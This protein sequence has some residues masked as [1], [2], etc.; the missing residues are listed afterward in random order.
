MRES[1]RSTC[2]RRAPRRAS[3]AFSLART[4]SADG[5]GTPEVTFPRKRP[6]G[7]PVFW[8]AHPG[9]DGRG[10]CA[11]WA[12]RWSPSSP[13]ACTRAKDAAELVAID[14]EDLPCV[15]DTASRDRR[16]AGLGRNARTTSRMLFEV[17]DA[18]ATDAAFARAARI[19]KGRYVIS[20]VHAQ[21]MEPRG[22]L[23]EYDAAS[24]ALHA[25]PRHPVPAPRARPAREPHPE[26][27]AREDP[28]GRAATSAARSAPRAGRATST[29]WCCG[30]RRS[31]AGPVKWTCERS[32]APLADEHG[33]DCISEAELALDANGKFSRCAYERRTTSARTCRRTAT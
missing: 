21:F 28:R 1:A 20:R 12:I 11:T 24:D 19:V 31:S 13:T 8:R 4:S 18:A 25:A 33:R 7:S 3:S 15:T 5:L 2:R 16:C 9:L 26:G 10:E 23:G 32:E 17:G 6:D 30:S 22:A 27:P 14:Y 29:G